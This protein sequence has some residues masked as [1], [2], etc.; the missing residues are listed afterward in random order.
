VPQPGEKTVRHVTR[1][2]LFGFGARILAVI[3]VQ[4]P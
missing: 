2:E 1:G 3:R 4:H